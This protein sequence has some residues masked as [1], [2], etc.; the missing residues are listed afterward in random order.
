[1][2]MHK[3]KGPFQV[4]INR[5][6]DKTIFFWNNSGE[7]W[8]STLRQVLHDNS[9]WHTPSHT[10]TSVITQSIPNTNNSP[11]KATTNHY[12]VLLDQDE[13]MEDLD[14]MIRDSD[15]NNSPKN[16]AEA[17]DTNKNTDMDLDP[18][19]CPNIM[20]ISAHTPAWNEEDSDGEAAHSEDEKSPTS[21]N[22]ENI[23]AQ[24]SETTSP[25]TTLI[26]SL[27]HPHNSFDGKNGEYLLAVE[28]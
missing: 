13:D 10:K 15:H 18:D 27:D 6:K 4:A 19:T 9:K 16:K 26:S 24:I 23:R 14:A 2:T 22:L 3:K 28:I 5:D 20:D 7:L 8:Q 11:S 21:I 12:N 25:A 1:M 17:G